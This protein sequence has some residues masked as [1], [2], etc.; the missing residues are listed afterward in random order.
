MSLSPYALVLEAV[1]YAEQD[2]F[3][4]FLETYFPV[5]WSDDAICSKCGLPASDHRYKA[6]CPNGETMFE[7]LMGKDTR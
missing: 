2:R 3:E 7:P 4:D 5:S 1:V 6:L